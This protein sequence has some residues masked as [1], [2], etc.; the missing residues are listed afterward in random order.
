MKVI[1]YIGINSAIR[2]AGILS[3]LLF[4]VLS[5]LTFLPLSFHTDTTEAAPG[6]ATESTITLDVTN[7]TASV[8]LTVSSTNGTFATSTTNNEASFSVTTNNYTGYT[9]SI[10]AADDTGTLDNGEYNLSSIAS[11]LTESEFNTT[12]NNGKWGYKPS[13]YNSLAN[14]DFIP[15]PTTEATTLDV[16]NT[17]NNEANSYTIGLGARAD[18]SSSAGTYT[19]TFILTAVG[20]PISYTIKYETGDYYGHQATNMPFPDNNNT[21]VGNTTSSTVTLASNVPEI[22]NAE[23]VNSQS[24]LFTCE[25]KIQKTYR[26]NRL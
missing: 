8:D 11:N 7:N 12:T 9:L 22:D 13:K 1:H 25:I 15:S 19:K 4:S 6:T 14:T 5:G 3:V 2:S 18:Y 26:I 10:S 17:A 21:Q 24:I 23:F 16:T 20:N